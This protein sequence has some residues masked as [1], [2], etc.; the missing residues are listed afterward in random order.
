MF[1]L[2]KYNNNSTKLNIKDGI[3][4]LSFN[5]LDKIDWLKNGF[6]TKKGGVSSGDLESMNLGITRGDSKENII[7]NYKRIS[8]AIGIE[9]YDIVL[10]AQTHTNNVLVADKNN[11][12]KGIFSDI[13][14]AD[15]DG[16]ITNEKNLALCAHFAD[17]VP[18][19][20]VDV[21]NKAIGLSHGG[22]RGT[23]NKIA[24]ETIKKMTEEYN[25]DPADV[26]VCIGPS[27]CVDCYEVSV[28]VAQNFIEL[29]PDK[30]DIIMYPK[31]DKYM[32]NLWEINR[33]LLLEAGVKYNNIF[34]TDICTCHN[35]KY[36][37]S[38]RASKG[39][40]GNLAAFL[41]ISN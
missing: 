21:K 4:Y 11:K 36:L 38:H 22:W 25:T 31:N 19:Y 15:V 34:I 5:V 9:P 18:L 39:R 6:S 28:D 7:E 27:I 32:L 29:M 35:P 17:C 20:F 26:I 16:L 2:N 41:E 14:Y 1:V 40:R 12:G 13:A 30:K 33:Q 37:F 10:T 24:P 8:S 3:P 23:L